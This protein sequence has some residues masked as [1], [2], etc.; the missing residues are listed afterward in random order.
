MEESVRFKPTGGGSF[1]PLSVYPIGSIYI[2]VSGTNPAELF[3]GTWQRLKDRF[4]LAAGDTYAA[5]STGGEAEHLL[6]ADEL[7]SHTHPLES[8]TG[9]DDM[10]FVNGSGSF[11]LQNS[12]TTIDW[13]SAKNAEMKY[14]NTGSVGGNKPHNNLP[15]YLAVY[16][17]VR[18]A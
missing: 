16:M 11:L 14:G 3:G 8:I 18:V 15:P 5:G 17:W 1:N 9:T 4:L 6:T 13:P 10:N 12:D 7:P 2:S